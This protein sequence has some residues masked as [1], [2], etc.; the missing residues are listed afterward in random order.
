MLKRL[1]PRARKVLRYSITAVVLV[2]VGVFF[3][4]ALIANWGEVQAA[5]LGFDPRMIVATLLFAL[6]VPL[7]GILWGRMVNRLS[8]GPRAGIA[9]SIAVHCASWLLKY[10]PGQVGSLVN[11]VVWGQRKGLSRTLIAI[12]FV[13]ENVFLVIAAT[14]P[15]VVILALALGLEVFGDNLGT[16]AL[17]LIALVP[18]LLISN[19][20]VFRFMLAPLV[21]RVLK[22]ELPDSYFLSSPA[23]LAYQLGYVVPRL[24]NGVGF[25]FVVVSIVDVDP[26]AW[27][28]LAAAYMLAGAA[29][30]LAVFVPSGLGVREAVI[31]LFASQYMSLGA[32]ILTS[33]LARLLSTLGDGIVALIYAGLRFSLPRA[34]Q[35]AVS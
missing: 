5:N 28:P 3:A 30:L 25:V 8:D 33:L 29:G 13:Y 20:R 18:L 21:K 27:L 23:T 16:L 2:V 22:Q 12:T 14:V 32:A 10:V 7:S 31:V 9:E 19:R 34:P 24:M 17:P 4:Q 15:S 11:K 35:E 1:S 26:S 6:A